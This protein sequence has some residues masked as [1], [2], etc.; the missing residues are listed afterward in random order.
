MITTQQLNATKQMLKLKVEREKKKYTLER[1][2]SYGFF[3]MKVFERCM[4]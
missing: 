4:H 2:Q 1:N 3:K